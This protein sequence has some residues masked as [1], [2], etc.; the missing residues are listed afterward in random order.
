VILSP[1]SANASQILLENIAISVRKII[2]AS[3]PVMDVSHV[4]VVMVRFLP[5]ANPILDNVNVLLELEGGKSFLLI[6]CY[7]H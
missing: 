1:E 2:L 6:C 3:V 7:S 4:I 5:D